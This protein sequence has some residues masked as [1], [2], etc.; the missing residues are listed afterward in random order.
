[1]TLLKLTFRSIFF[2]WRSH[3]LILSG[4]I[5]A[6]AV[7]AGALLVGDSIK[8]S[9]QQSALLRL[10]NIEWGMESRGRFFPADL[11]DRLQ[12]ETGVTVSPALFFR[13]IALNTK[14][15]GAEPRQINDIQI[16]GVTDSFWSFATGSKPTLT[17]DGIAINEKLAHELKLRRGDQ[18]SIR[19]S[20]P[21]PVSRD[22]PLSAQEKNDTLRATF[23]VEDI[24]GDQQLGRFNLAAN[25]QIPFTVFVRLPS[26][27]QSAGVNHQAN[28]L[29]AC[30]STNQTAEILNQAIRK[31]RQLADAGLTLR[32]VDGG[33]LFQ[34]E[35]DRIFMDPPIG[36]ALADM[37][38]SVGALTYLVNSISRTNG[39][40]IRETPYSFIV[41]LAPSTDQALGLVPPDM[42]DDGIIINRWLADQLAANPG[43]AVKLT[44]FEFGALN[45]FMETNRILK[46]QRIASMD[47][48]AGEKELGPKF[49][50]LTEAGKCADWNVGMPMQKDKLEDPANEAYWNAYRATPKAIVTLKAGQEMW[51]NRF[52]NLTAIR[53]R[54]NEDGAEAIAETVLQHLNPAELGFTFLP[55]RQAALKAASEAMD[56][57]QLFLG[58]SLFLI[59]A[60]LM[61]TGLLFAFG[62]QQRSAE[63]GLMLS[64]GFQPGQIRRLWIQECI[65]IALA[66]SVI[67]TLFGTFYTQTLIWSLSHYW[68]GAVARA[69]I[70][71]HATSSTMV[72]G[73]LLSFV[74]AMGSLLLTI[75]RQTARSARDLFSGEEVRPPKRTISGVRRLTVFSYTGVLIVF[76]LIA[77]ATQEQQHNPA[78]IFFGAGSLLLIS[79]LGF[80]RLLLVRLARTGGRL[81]PL[82]LGL[83]NAGRQQSRSLTVASLLACGCF[84]VIA[85]SS[86]Q[87]NIEH[88][89]SR[90]DSGTGGFTLF[91]HSTLPIQAAL[92]TPEGLQMMQLDPALKLNVTNIVSMK[93][94][95]GDDAS[96]LNLN[97][98]QSPTLIGVDPDDFRKRGAFE[99]RTM[100]PGIWR[101]L[102]ES[103]PGGVIP[104]LVGDANTAQWG[105][106]SKTGKENGDILVF[107]N[108]RGE[109]FRVKLVGTLPMRLSVFQG[110]ILIPAH[111][112][113]VQYPSENGARMFLIDTP[114]DSE[115]RIK[116]ALTLKLGKWGANF[117]ST[118]ERLRSFYSVEAT[119]MA[120][121]LVLGG[122]GLL[123]GSAGMTVVI[124]RNI[125]ERRNELALLTA[126]GYSERQVIN[127]VLAEHGVI[128]GIG[129][130][131]GIT[132][133]LAAI[134]PA[135][136]TPGDSLHWVAL[137]VIICGMLLFQV[138]WLLLATR[139]ALR[140]PL[141][142][143]LRNQ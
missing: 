45:K 26:L 131:T 61:L 71:Y 93:V 72:T 127:V 48:F 132:A 60:S 47:D 110:S 139:I 98:A 68:Q 24:V 136:Q 63:T 18:L 105:L 70:Q 128:L 33:R 66:G 32:T 20:K 8:F 31:V 44:Y 106:K 13:G 111:A 35:C 21:S 27:Q 62:I 80:A 30:G 52:G 141:L 46:I 143:A 112:F 15:P 130:I 116:D 84:L 140:A 126:T 86:M 39:N 114:P 137:T 83:R 107:R 54:A 134:W 99:P 42:P 76:G 119:Y 92:N 121:F 59:V 125:Q 113:A 88:N 117:T 7:L 89:A 19:F 135:L 53:F 51:A 81:T 40:P 101:Q 97:R 5:L 124:L 43:D 37:T 87:E 3:A 38:K 10:G 67:G 102:D 34:L 73:A 2:Y 22:A 78:P 79:L 91:G 69:E 108:E 6:A 16:L 96:C 95:D 103:L 65:L 25:Q 14:P 4:A 123:L 120:M 85:V 133:S 1:M 138:I 64:V 75:Q 56:F 77:F 90:R 57:G 118:T 129:L 115:R 55:I 23:M 9:L 104:G 142:N 50:G 109:P 28:L 74:F 49:P 41:A 12:A 82:T 94:R 29:L 58:M 36:A 11:A 122:L 17:P 100:R